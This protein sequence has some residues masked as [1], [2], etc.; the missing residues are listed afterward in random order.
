MNPANDNLT[1][2]VNPGPADIVITAGGTRHTLPF[3]TYQEAIEYA[4][5]ISDQVATYPALSDEEKA[6]DVLYYDNDHG[7]V[8]VFL[9]PQI[10][11][12]AVVP[13][14][15]VVVENTPDEDDPQVEID[16]WSQEIIDAAD[17]EERAA[18]YQAHEDFIGTLDE[19]PAE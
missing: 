16:A 3:A 9:I 18:D 2:H 7:L 17:E 15:P 6:Q 1:V 11:G 19:I 14:Q 4:E 8:A 13:G 12:W 10:A 5:T